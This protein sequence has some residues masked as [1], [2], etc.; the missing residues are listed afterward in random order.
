MARYC[1]LTGQVIHH[2]R[3]RYDDQPVIET[4]TPAGLKM[5]DDDPIDL[6]QEQI[7]GDGGLF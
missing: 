3:F 1:D 6:F 2:L 4:D 5:E 7:G